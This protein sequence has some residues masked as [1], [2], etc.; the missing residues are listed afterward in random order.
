MLITFFPKML[1]HRCSTG[2]YIRPC[3]QLYFPSEKEAN[4]KINS[5]R[6]FYT[7]TNSK[8]FSDSQK[9]WSWVGWHQR[10]EMGPF[11]L[12]LI[13]LVCFKLIWSCKHRIWYYHFWFRKCVRLI[14]SNKFDRV[15]AAEIIN[16]L[17][18]L[19]IFAKKLHRRGLREFYIRHWFRRLI[20]SIKIK[21]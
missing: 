13:W 15:L 12:K 18:P 10:V 11:L 8:K 19:I 5:L 16:S 21:E 14:W 20:F 2:F 6:T 17:K 7:L 3:S 9:K 4:G 1:H